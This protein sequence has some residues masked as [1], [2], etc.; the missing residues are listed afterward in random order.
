MNYNFFAGLE[1]KKQVLDFVFNDLNLKVYDLYSDF[2]QELNEYKNTDEILNKFQLETETH[3]EIFLN[4][5]SP[6]FGG[7]M[8]SKRITLDPR[9][10]KGHTFRFSSEG[11]GLVQLYLGG[12]TSDYLK[13]CH[14]GH[15]SQKRALAWENTIK[16]TSSVEDWNWKNIE[17]VAK[18][19]KYHIHN[20]LAL[21]KEQAYGIL[22]GADALE[23]S[24]IRL[25]GL[26]KFNPEV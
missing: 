14:L 9:S 25:A 7:N 3:P 6:D 11:W 12:I 4:L 20:R 21:R 16:R 10:C 22:A 18:K 8:E 19:L 24:G 17:Q 2:G 15:N 26:Q 1:D 23:R 13:S 5:W